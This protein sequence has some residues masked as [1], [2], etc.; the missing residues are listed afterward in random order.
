[1]FRIKPKKYKLWSTLIQILIFIF[2]GIII[3]KLIFL[4]VIQSPDLKKQSIE[5]RSSDRNFSFRGEIFDRNGIRLAGDTTIYDIYAHPRYYVEGKGPKI[6]AEVMAKP[7]KQP[8]WT[9]RDKLSKY[10]YSTISIAKNVNVDIVEK[11]IKPEIDK[12]GIRG[13]DF[14]K[15]NKRIYPQ[16]N[17]ASH[18]LGY[19][20]F[21]A[22]LAAGVERTG[23]KSLVCM[24]EARPIEYDGRGNVIYD[25]HTDPEKITAP[26]KGS[27]LVLTIDSAIQLAAETELGKMVRK[28]NADRGT[29]IVLNPK[30]GEILGFALYPNYDP[31]KYNI[32]NPSVIK[33][34][35]LSDVYPPG[36]TFKILTVASALG[37]GAITKH[38]TIEDTG[39]IEI[40]GWE[41]K[42]HDYY[43]NPNPGFIGLEELFR[44][45]S[46][47]AS[48]KIA[49]KMS[50]YDY[51]R[52][53][54]LFGI[55]MKT[56]IDLPG[57]SSGILPDIQK[58]DRATQGAIGYGYSIA[59]TPMQMATSVAAIANKGIWTT[60]H[61]IK[62]Y[63]NPDRIE[64]IRILSE[65]NCEIVTQ[66]LDESI[67][68]SD[69][70]AGKLGK[71]RVAGKSGT[72]KKPNPNGSGYTSEVYAS[73]IG[74][75]PAEN[76]EA[77]ILVVVDN[78]K[79][80]EAWGSAVAGPVFNAV[81]EEV[82]RVLNL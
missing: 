50:P 81:A 11:K 74:Y 23:H 16:G 28:T 34:W 61:V 10:E 60:P 57:E 72:S 12:Q 30:N 64:K 59:T 71:Y 3:L 67:R 58:W 21:D 78:P 24:P 6:I 79:N 1:M 75:F 25:F 55:G 47:V 56:G 39:K 18:I 32:F 19:I 22:N 45:S 35:A 37:T 38:E 13:L 42:N 7:L 36:S 51:Y 44:R 41:I 29:V 82:G 2:T 73:F 15:K 77:L 31:N 80:K 14:V 27:K 63:E 17:L 54:N 48:L 4:Q 76:P 26:L 65:K 5:N 49:L 8:E 52:M 40:Q 20:N 53:L 62:N 46:N 33:N 68:K 9:L 43:K 70:E 69:S 66:L